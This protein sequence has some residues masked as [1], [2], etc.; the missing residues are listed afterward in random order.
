MGRTMESAIRIVQVTDLHL[1]AD[2]ADTFLDVR[3]AETAA[4]VFD[5]I[6]DLEPAPDLVVAT[7]D[8]T[9]DGEVA[10]Y[11]R[12]R[13]LAESLPCEMRCVLGNHD[14]RRAFR[15]GWEGQSMPDD[16][17]LDYT[18]DIGGLRLIVLDTTVPGEE[19]GRLEEDQLR[20]LARQ[21]DAAGPAPKIILLHHHPVEVGSPW[22]DR[23]MLS[24]GDDFFRAIAPGKATTLGIIFGHVHQ[25]FE[26][27]WEGVPVLGTRPT[28]VPFTPRTDRFI[29]SDDPPGYRVV[30]IE[31]GRLQSRTVPVPRPP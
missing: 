6:R 12:L 30:E 31:D 9:Q 23:M 8:L 28:S 7:G 5:A 10:S 24:N 14:G 1:T 2:P 17:P 20:W 25:D 18:F 26:T 11:R 3:T 13:T 27:R 22:M 15:A 16:A 29:P 21:V 19:G 4:R